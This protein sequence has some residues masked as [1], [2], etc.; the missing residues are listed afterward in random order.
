M[1]ENRDAMSPPQPTRQ[2]VVVRHG[3]TE[4]SRLGK[5]T[6]R[7]DLPLTVTGEQ[8]ARALR[9]RLEAQTF[10]RVLCSPLLRA[11]STAAL[12]GFADRA[13]TFLD[14]TE[15]NYGDDEGKTTSEIRTERERPDWSIWR[16]GPNNGET[17]KEV[18]ARADRVIAA[19]MTAKGDVLAFAHG[20]ILDAIAARWLGLDASWG[21]VF[22]LD[23][24]SVSILGFHNQE[25]VLRTWNS[26]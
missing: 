25:R 1:S 19:V 11:K 9:K 12:S 26:R 16:E 2:F 8:D 17:L 4:W 23:P 21:R 6:G 15:W 7:T 20:H 13:E 24:A 10:A 5:H 18:S 22:H 14:L 3:E